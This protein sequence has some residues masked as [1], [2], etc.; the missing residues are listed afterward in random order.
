LIKGVTGRDQKKEF[1]I[2]QKL[3]DNIKNNDS[4]DEILYNCMI[5]ACVATHNFDLAK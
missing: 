3:F 2:I 1:I 4:P 5:D